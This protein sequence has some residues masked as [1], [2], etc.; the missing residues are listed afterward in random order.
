VG[1]N[2]FSIK[3]LIEINLRKNPRNGGSPAKERRL[4]IRNNLSLRVS[5][6]VLIEVRWEKDKMEHGIEMEI[7]MTI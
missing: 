3:M 4:I 6:F 7:I 5:L 1:F 2:L